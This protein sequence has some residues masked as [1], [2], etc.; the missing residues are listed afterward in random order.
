MICASW[1]PPR[2][3]YFDTWCSHP[4]T[5]LRFSRADRSRV[6]EHWVVFDGRRSL[7]GNRVTT[8][9]ADR[10]LNA[11]LNLGYRLAGIEARLAAMA[12]GLAPGLP[13]ARPV[14]L[15]QTDCRA[16]R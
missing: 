9:R 1:K 6:P 13:P 16:G 8:R 11:L 10:P 14:C 7:L 4:A 3:P 5:T 2:L 12:V 15:R